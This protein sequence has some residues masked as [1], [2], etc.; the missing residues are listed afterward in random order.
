MCNERRIGFATARRP[1]WVGMSS[2][3]NAAESPGSDT[4]RVGIA[5]VLN[6]K[7]VDALSGWS[8]SQRSCYRVIMCM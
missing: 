6:V 7:V 1:H 5:V 8:T 3:V 4:T 2:A